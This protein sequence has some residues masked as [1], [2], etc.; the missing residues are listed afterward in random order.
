MY[1]LEFHQIKKDVVQ[2]LI[3]PAG[4]VFVFV[5]VLL[6]AF[7]ICEIFCVYQPMRQ[8]VRLGVFM[9]ET[10]I[11]VLLCINQHLLDPLIPSLSLRINRKLS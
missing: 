11:P 7:E 5:P 4:Y 1:S 10:H 3:R 6:V 9:R 8:T 2:I